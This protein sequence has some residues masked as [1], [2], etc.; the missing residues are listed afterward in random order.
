MAGDEDTPENLQDIALVE[1]LERRQEQWTKLRHT[2]GGFLMDFASFESMSLTAVLKALS[3]DDVLV[4]HLPEHTDLYPRLKLMK[5]LG[6]ARRLPAPLQEDIG[7]LRKVANELRDCRN[8]IAH[9]YAV[10]SGVANTAAIEQGAPLKP[11]VARRRSERNMPRLGEADVRSL[12]QLRAKVSG[13]G[14]TISRRS[15]SGP[16]SR[17][18]CRS[19]RAS[20]PRSWDGTGG[21]R[22]GRASWCRAWRCR[23]ERRRAS[24]RDPAQRACTC[25]GVSVAPFRVGTPT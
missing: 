9:G 23:S 15:A 24:R 6:V 1:Q 18:S 7:H 2:I 12:E 25:G 10:L 19:R 3:Y 16:R 22:T 14:S 11:V 4:E 20:S 8:D 21:V 13:S 5:Q 17:C